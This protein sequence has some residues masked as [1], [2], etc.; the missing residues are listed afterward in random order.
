MVSNKSFP[1][2]DVICLRNKTNLVVLQTNKQASRRARNRQG[3][4]SEK[5]KFVR[6]EFGNNLC[7][8][9]ILLASA[10]SLICIIS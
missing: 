8:Q 6:I 10:Y 1:L 3:G 5:G 9:P 2:F 4:N 7:E